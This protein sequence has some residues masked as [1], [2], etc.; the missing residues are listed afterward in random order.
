[1]AEINVRKRG[2]KWE[3]RF[4][5]AKINGKRKQIGKGGFRTKKEALEA[6]AEALAEYKKSGKSFKPSEMSF[7][8]LLDEW[9]ENY[10]K[11]ELKDTTLIGYEK[12]IRC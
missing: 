7:S 9:Y 4:E 3:Y 2:Q 11:V 6:G 12:N 5:A 10:C 1:M 8:D